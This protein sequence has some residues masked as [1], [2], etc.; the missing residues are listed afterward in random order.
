[1]TDY[2]SRAATP[3]QREPADSR[4]VQNEAGGFVYETDLWT[5][6][7][8]F[9][10]LGSEGGSYYASERDLTREQIQVLH[11][12]LAEDGP[13]AVEAIAG[14]SE[15]GRAPKNTPAIFAL[16]YAA[17]HGDEKT[18]RAAYEA[19]PRVCR[20]GTHLFEFLNYAQI[21]GGWGRGMKR[22][23]QNW[24]GRDFERVAFQM[25]KYRQREGW[26]HGDVLRM[27]KPVVP[28]DSPH[29][30]LF[31]WAVGKGGPPTDMILAYESAQ[32]ANALAT[33]TAIQEHG[34]TREMIDPAHLTDARVWDALLHNS[35]PYTALIRNLGTMSRVGLLTPGS[36]AVGEVYRRLADAD[37]IR[38]ARVHPLTVLTALATYNRGYGYRSDWPVIPQVVDALNAAFYMAFGNVEPS[39]K[40]VLLGIDIS[41]SMARGEVAGSPLRPRE[42]AGAMALVTAKTEPHYMVVGF[43]QD[44]VQIPVSPSQRLD[45]VVALI[46]QSLPQ[47]TDCAVP[48]NFAAAKEWAF[49]AIVLY[50]DSQT[51]AGNTQ[52]GEALRRYRDRVSPGAKLVVCAMVANKYTVGDPDDPDTLD[53]VGFDTATPNLITDFVAERI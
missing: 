37:A 52:V 28:A 5:R 2:L 35:L 9:L 30:A 19:L 27:A 21:F 29:D 10:V 1:M 6:L 39:H 23:I 45:D 20:I 46:S 32:G 26:T 24:Y 3:T 17:K 4:Q 44:L 12:A 48:I 22:A 43:T 49:D 15:G 25:L 13:R 11:E 34:L 51:W 41:G 18:R 47:G 38:K 53:V 16:A 40:R 36:A 8:R 7:N 33:V 42:A 31:A 50:T 14:V